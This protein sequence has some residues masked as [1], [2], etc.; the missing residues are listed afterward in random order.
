MSQ[1]YNHWLGGLT[2]R[3]INWLSLVR[4]AAW[5]AAGFFVFNVGMTGVVQA[6][7]YTIPQYDNWNNTGLGTQH[8]TKDKSPYLLQGGCT[9]NTLPQSRS[10]TVDPGVVVK[11]GPPAQCGYYQYPAQLIIYGTLIAN[12]TIDE[13]IIFTS[14]HD[15]AVAG[16]TNANGSATIPKA[17]DWARLQITPQSVA[18]VS[19]T[20]AVIR[21]GGNSSQGMMQVSG[22]LSNVTLGPVD[23]A[24]SSSYG[25]STSVPHVLTGSSFHHNVTAAIQTLGATVDARWCW[26]GNNSGPQAASN[27]GGTGDKIIG[28]VIYDPWIGKITNQSPVLSWLGVDGYQNDGIDPSVS[29][30][31]SAPIFKVVYTDPDNDAPA[32]LKLFIDYIGYDMVVEPGQD[33][34]FRNGET[35]SFTPALDSLIKGL[36]QYHFETSDSQASFRLP[37]EGELPFE[38]RWDPVIIIPGILG[39]AEKNDQWVIDPILH[40]Y[41]NLIDTLKVNG[42]VD[43]QDLFTLPYDWR[44]SNILTAVKLKDKINEVKSICQCSQV[45]LVV[46][47]MGGLVARSYIQSDNYENDVNQLIFL[48]TPH[49][50]AP[51]SYLTW[52]GGE[53]TPSIF[54]NFLKFL[55]TIE[56]K[57]EGFSNIFNYVKNRPIVSVQQLLPIYDYLRDKDTGN[58]RVYPNNYPQ[59]IFLEDLKN[60]ISRLLNSGINVSNVVSDRVTST[61]NVIRVV[62]YATGPL[63][64]HGYPDGFDGS[65]IDNGLEKGV[66]DGTVPISSASFIAN[67][68]SNINAE[69]RALPSEAEGLIFKKLTN[70][71]ASV[72]VSASLIVRK[73]LLIK[74]L[75][76]VDVVITAPDGK[77]I[78][79]DFQTNQELNEMEG[80][81][82]S[83]F[84]GDDEYVVIP[85]PLDGEYLVQTQG[86][87]NGGTYTVAV[88][89][90]SDE[91][92]IERDFT[93]QTTPGLITELKLKVDNTNPVALEVKPADITPPQ[94]TVTSP[95]SKDYLRSEELPISFAITDVESGVVSQQVK[96]NER[97]IQNGDQIDLF[98]EKLGEYKLQASAADYVGNAA[99]VEVPF[100]VV[101]TP[102]S[103]ISDIHRAYTLGWITNKGI[104]ESLIRKLKLIVKLE[105]RAEFIEERLPGKPK[106]IKKIEK[107]EEKIDRVLAKFLLKEIEKQHGKH[108]NDQAYYLLIE[109]INWL[110]ND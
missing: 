77:R 29:F 24:Y 28:N 50:G 49:L 2:K 43:G 45:D 98:Y 91:E 27:P 79:K 35:Y 53:V 14:W 100:R 48:G 106:L 61:V 88:G 30:T 22:S 62:P 110:L 107:V 93:A 3:P 76:P 34:D 46:H 59:N 68:L 32:A 60:T 69:H 86:T 56:A 47:S 8:W 81:F 36:R 42:Y 19:I 12:G 65:T 4:L 64:E 51:A 80:A 52:E 10:I 63:W 103:T 82:Y 54:S 26:W 108:I 1:E 105:K 11:F 40:T 101:A 44:W 83:G 109:D 96:L 90:I 17:G 16:D 37:V 78:G 71:E 18:T 85:N 102:T 99:E 75:S 67:D 72:L 94:I 97:I 5:C 74:L 104:E 57:K 92:S 21:Y 33:G 20:N 6:A 58:L 55:F 25:L 41:D 38:V 66:G 73:I 39:S 95:T 84:V 89:Y 23:V 87:D 70:Q 9:N 31:G 13:P 7:S 15:D